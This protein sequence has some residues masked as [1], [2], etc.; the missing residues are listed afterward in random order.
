MSHWIHIMRRIG[1]A[2]RRGAGVAVA[3]GRDPRRAVLAP[4]SRR[5]LTSPT[6]QKLDFG[7]FLDNEYVEAEGGKRLEVLSPAD[8]T[9]FAAIADAAV[10]DV[11][12]AVASARRTFDDDGGAWR[13]TTPADRAKLLT[14]MADALE[15]DT[16]DWAAI[17][18]MDCGKTFAE[19]VGDMGFCVNVLR[20]Y[21]EIVESAMR[22]TEL[23]VDEGYAARIDADGCGVVG[24]ITPWNYPL[25]QAV[26]KVAPAVAAGCTVVLKPSPLASLT[27]V[28]LGD[29]AR[30][31]GVPPGVLN[32]VTGGPPMG[33]PEASQALGS[34]PD[35]DRLSFTGSGPTG[36]RLLHASADHLRP[37]SLELGGKGAMLVFPDADLDAVAEWVAVGIFSTSGQVCSATSRLLVHDS[38]ADDLIQRVL[39][40]TA[41]VVVGHPLDDRST[42]GPVVSAEQ[43]DKVQ[44]AI[45]AAEAEGCTVAAGGSSDPDV[46]TECQGGYYVQPTVLTDVPITSSA[47]TD[48]IFG[49]VLSVRQFGSENEAVAAANDSPYGL[50]HA[51]MTADPDRLAR[52][53][54]RLRAGV[55]YEN[56]SQ[57]GFAN[58]P[59]GGCKKSG[60]GW[61]WGEAGLHEYIQHKT[62]V[63]AL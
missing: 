29:L 47:W 42:M 62:V 58:T 25:M 55:V 37:T 17:E 28:M 4:G 5:H 23:A 11:D 49:P 9:P 13:Q 15:R 1:A 12:R 2:W 30:Q 19:S 24:C 21:A 44:Q 10:A 61:E 57:M 22:S 18:S 52:V 33:L 46:G 59:F 27:T 60:F 35:L 48:E 26:N 54:R 41:A 16:D 36:A 32:I 63:A 39:T 53:A 20:F 56:C 40:R 6:E 7:L 34:H 3:A 51:V 8:G 50:A 38:I 31:A 14:S 45:A 43:R